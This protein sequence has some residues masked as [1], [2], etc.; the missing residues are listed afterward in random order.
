MWKFLKQLLVWVAAVPVGLLGIL[1]IA[2][3]AGST[4]ANNWIKIIM[5][6]IQQGLASPW[7][8]SIVGILVIL[9]LALYFVCDRRSEPK[10]QALQRKV[11]KARSEISSQ[12]LVISSQAICIAQYRIEISNLTSQL[13]R[14]KELTEELDKLATLR[15]RGERLADTV[16]FKI[17]NG[18][19]WGETCDNIV[20]FMHDVLSIP[21]PWKVDREGL[22][23]PY[24]VK[25]EKLQMGGPQSIKDA[26]AQD[27][28]GVRKYVQAGVR[29]ADSV[30]Q[31][32]ISR[33]V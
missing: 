32:L 12:H 6:A 30:R 11:S 5:L 14:Q 19:N 13:V 27:W 4:V 25:R 23:I 28:I 2:G 7:D 20:A 21:P 22:Y 24:F 29:E 31:Q 3:Q 1:G 33:L 17:V 26:N 15:T 8:L 16:N 9:W 18:S 10:Y